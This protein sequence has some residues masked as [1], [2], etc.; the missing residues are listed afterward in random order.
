M[1]RCSWLGRQGCNHGHAAKGIGAPPKGA[2][3]DASSSVRT[4]HCRLT[5]LV[6]RA[7]APVAAS[8]VGAEL[9]DPQPVTGSLQND[10]MGARR[11]AGKATRAR[12]DRASAMRLATAGSTRTTGGCCQAGGAQV[13]LERRHW[14]TPLRRHRRGWP[15]PQGDCALSRVALSRISSSGSSELVECQSHLGE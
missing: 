15:A 8:R 1:A 9:E 11:A 13:P 7:C 4:T 5:T 14:T 3:S 12:L 2:W 10:A 6:S